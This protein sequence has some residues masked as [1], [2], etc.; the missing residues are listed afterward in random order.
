MLIY[1]K[2][3]LLWLARAQRPLIRAIIL[4]VAKKFPAATLRCAVKG[5]FVC[6]MTIPKRNVF[7]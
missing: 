3:L 4:E 6:M 7:T 1:A 5:T 2:R